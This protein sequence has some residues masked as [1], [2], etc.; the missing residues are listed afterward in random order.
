MATAKASP[1]RLHTMQPPP[2][3]EPGTPYSVHD[4]IARH[5]GTMSAK[6]L[7]DY[8]GISD[9]LVYARANA[10]TIPR[11]IVPGSNKMRF[12]PAT[13][14][15]WLRKHNPIMRQIARAS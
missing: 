6:Q 1:R 8:L 4:A 9:D 3:P 10:G 7:G 14:C 2:E 12:D 15:F 13:I 11:V 5:Q